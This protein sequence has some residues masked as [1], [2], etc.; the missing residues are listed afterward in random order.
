MYKGDFKC[1]EIELVRQVNAFENDS[2]SVHNDVVKMPNGQT[3]HYHRVINKSNYRVSVNVI[4][5]DMLLLLKIFSHNERRWLWATPQIDAKSKSKPEN[6]ALYCIN[7]QAGYTS[8]HLRESSTVV[9][10]N[11]PFHLFHAHM[12][13]KCTPS[14]EPN[15]CIKET[16]LFS[17][18]E[19]E[20]LLNTGKIEL[21]TALGV[22]DFL[23]NERSDMQ[24]RSI[25]YTLYDEET[26]NVTSALKVDELPN[27][28]QSKYAYTAGA[29]A[30]L[31]GKSI[32]FNPYRNRP[33][34]NRLEKLWEK[35]W[36]AVSV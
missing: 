18:E 8:E 27:F 9:Y 17:R 23:R 35:G 2:I 5:D 28:S 30:K 22:L 14:E 3:G 33:E 20:K 1:G 4:L 19:A 36:M 6:D 34:L 31:C 15:S 11:K 12:P 32:H 16:R 21:S 7:K 26:L 13:I 25:D 29:K 10:N 24:T